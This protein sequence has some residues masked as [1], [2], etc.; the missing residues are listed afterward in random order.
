MSNRPWFIS[1]VQFTTFH[2]G[3]SC[4]RLQPSSRNPSRCHTARAWHGAHTERKILGSPI[5]PTWLRFP[6][7]HFRQSIVDLCMIRTIPT[8][9]ILALLYY[10]LMVSVSGLSIHVSGCSA[11]AE[12]DYRQFCAR[13]RRERRNAGC[14]GLI[15]DARSSR[16]HCDVVCRIL[17]RLSRSRPFRH[18][19]VLSRR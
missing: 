1:D 12:A 8:N 5:V 19:H 2:L 10:C 16:A 4:L 3:S 18:L 13:F 7:A 15:L 11:D 17:S 14:A 9:E 6:V